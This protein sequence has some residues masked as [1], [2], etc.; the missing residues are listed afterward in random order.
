M[1]LM[2]GFN[3]LD[4]LLLL[5]LFLAMFV[6]YAQGV[7]RQVINL[8]ALYVAAILAAQ[9]HLLLAAG[10]RSVLVDLPSR[11]VNGLAF[12]II[13]IVVASIV[14]WLALDAYQSMR[15]N[16]FPAIDHLGGGVV[17]LITTIVAITL[18]LPVLSF[19]SLEVWPTAEPARQFIHDG[20]TSSNMLQVFESLKP[21]MLGVLGPWLPG[22][23]P[24][25]FNI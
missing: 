5:L 6:G 10:I 4:I 25:I 15:L 23:L 19:T 14:G 2:A 21:Y 3:W 20:L 1:G 12:F 11:F 22:G 18:V 7:M 13:V 8:A 16:I 24:S 9:Y 17:A